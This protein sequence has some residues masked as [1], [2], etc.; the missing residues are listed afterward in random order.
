MKESA[1]YVSAFVPDRNAPHAG[2]QAA[3]QNLQDLVRQGYDVTVLVCTSE[4][5]FRK[6]EK[7][8]LFIKQS[9]WRLLVAWLMDIF[10]RKQ[11]ITP[12]WIHLNTRANCRFYAELNRQIGTNNFD[13][14]FVDFTQAYLPVRRTLRDMAKLPTISLCIP[15]LYIQKLL[16]QKS[17]AAKLLFSPVVRLEQ[18]ILTEVNEIV[19][20]SEK[21]ALIAKH[22]YGCKNTRSRIFVAPDWT[23]LVRRD[24]FTPHEVLF[25]ANFQRPENIEALQWFVSEAMPK[26]VEELPGFQ[27]VIAGYGSDTVKLKNDST[28]IKRL[29][30]I[31][32]PSPVFSSCRLAIAPLAMGAGVKYKV[33]EAIAAGVPVLGTDVAMEGVPDSSLLHQANRFDFTQK[34]IDLISSNN[35]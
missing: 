26:I 9:L 27:L 33:L 24:A 30:F 25:F 3:F 28:H 18:T 19:T 10:S 29:G 15:D 5:H 12:A 21:D 8:E 6:P 34:L 16:R 4:T 31:H 23:N 32:D 7:G 13:L 20:H 1:L 2:G 11:Q 22:L 14:I 17:L 35:P